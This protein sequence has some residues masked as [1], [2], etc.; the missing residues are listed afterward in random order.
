MSHLGTPQH[1][2]YLQHLDC[3]KRTMQK[4]EKI[5][6]DGNLVYYLLDTCSIVQHEETG[7]QKTSDVVDLINKRLCPGQ[8][9]TRSHCVEFSTHKAYNCRKTRP[10]V[11][12]VYSVYIEKQAE[13]EA[14]K[15]DL[16]KEELKR[17][18]EGIKVIH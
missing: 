14:K 4:K 13:R 1:N 9:C 3:I 15:Q 12:K 16:I 5:D 7:Y 11:C 17:I 2:L 8:W 6:F 18:T 10:K